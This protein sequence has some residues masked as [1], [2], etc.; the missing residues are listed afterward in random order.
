MSKE[1][2]L[3][4]RIKED[5]INYEATVQSDLGFMGWVDSTAIGSRYGS[6]YNPHMARE[7]LVS[8][9][10]IKVA[11]AIA[12]LNEAIYGCP[13]YLDK[14][15]NE[16]KPSYDN[17]DDEYEYEDYEDDGYLADDDPWWYDG[18]EVVGEDW[19]LN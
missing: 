7:D 2:R 8:K 19:D 11:N 6:A 9:L 1:K 4:I 3:V 18:I 10:R 5:G 16:L 13:V 17:D 14:D 12:E 15:G